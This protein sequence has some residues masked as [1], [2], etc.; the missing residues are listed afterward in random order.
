M[1]GEWAQPNKDNGLGQ[2]IGSAW[3]HGKATPDNLQPF[4]LPFFP[5]GQVAVVIVIL[6]V[7]VIDSPEGCGKSPD[8]I[9]ITITSHDY[10]RERRPAS[11][12]SL[13]ETTPR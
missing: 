8:S 11:R 4:P 10:E 9:K 12:P 1:K 6:I 13:S 5:S 7:I 2:G 3:L